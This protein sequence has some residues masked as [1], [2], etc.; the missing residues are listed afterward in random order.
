MMM[1]G[2]CVR[3]SALAE[4][5][6]DEEGCTLC[7]DYNGVMSGYEYSVMCVECNEMYYFDEEEGLGCVPL[8]TVE[9][10]Y[11]FEDLCEECVI[12]DEE[13]MALYE[14]GEYVEMMCRGCN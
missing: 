10:D 9:C 6:N 7:Y 14:E 12:H 2:Q 3:F 8:P 1:R 4:C 13:M 5:A 11:G